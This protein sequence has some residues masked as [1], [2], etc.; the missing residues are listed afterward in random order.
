[1]QMIETRQSALT[2]QSFMALGETYVG[3]AGYHCLPGSSEQKQNMR[4]A[5]EEFD[6]A[7]EGEWLQ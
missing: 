2:A 5:E 3:S 7:M 1:M 4:T 6:R